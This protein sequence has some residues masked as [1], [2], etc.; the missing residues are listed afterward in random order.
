MA[1]AFIT[2]YSEMA[3]EPS[4]ETIPVGGKIVDTQ[5]VSFTVSAQS[6][7]FKN[8]TRF[9]RVVTDAK[10]HIAFGTGNPTATVSD[11][12]VPSNTPEYFGV[13]KGSKIAFY[14]GSS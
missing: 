12:F 4:G 10:A 2:E 13:K 3:T 6:L 8:K 1:S 9:V 14:D 7:A 11:P 5:E